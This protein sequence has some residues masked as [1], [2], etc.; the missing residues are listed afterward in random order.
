MSVSFLALLDL[1]PNSEELPSFLQAVTCKPSPSQCSGFE[2][3]PIDSGCLNMPI[4]L[5][6]ELPGEDFLL[7]VNGGDGNACEFSGVS[8]VL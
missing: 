8:S 3:L 5:N 2:V 6:L 1:K 7:T 4:G